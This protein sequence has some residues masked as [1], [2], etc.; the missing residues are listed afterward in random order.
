MATSAIGIGARIIAGPAHVELVLQ[1]PL[2]LFQGIVVAA[3]ETAAVGVAEVFEHG[4]RDVLR[5]GAASLWGVVHIDGDTAMVHEFRD[6][7]DILLG[8][9]RED[10]QG[11]LVEIIDR[12]GEIRRQ[13]P[14]GVMPIGVPAPAMGGISPIIHHL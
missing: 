5:E 13:L 8:R 4:T 7:V 10:A 12:C 11:H 14:I 3:I 9:A 2:E 6:G 1:Q